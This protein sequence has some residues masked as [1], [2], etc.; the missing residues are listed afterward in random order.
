MQ[1][2]KMGIATIQR[3]MT[4]L[5]ESGLIVFKGAPKT[6]VYKLIDRFKNN[7]KAKERLNRE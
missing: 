6:G 7:I 2:F 1:C 4:L 5:K 3:D